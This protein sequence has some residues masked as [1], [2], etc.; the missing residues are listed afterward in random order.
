MS[1]T[2]DENILYEIRVIGIRNIYKVSVG[3]YFLYDGQ[4][5]AWID[6]KVITG[7]N[8]LFTFGGK[9]INCNYNALLLVEE[10]RG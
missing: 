5:T 2:V 1:C 7:M 10:I 8:T 9:L 4:I 6:S 3:V